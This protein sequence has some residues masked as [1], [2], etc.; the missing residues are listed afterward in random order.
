MLCV[1]VLL[2]A[3]LLAVNVHG[4]PSC[5]NTMRHNVTAL[6]SVGFA[7]VRMSASFC[8]PDSDI[9]GFLPCQ[10]IEVSEP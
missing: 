5:P 7:S 4:E 6:A 8:I 1:N 9:V 3:E 2:E 10:M